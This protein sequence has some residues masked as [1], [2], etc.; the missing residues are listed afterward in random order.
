VHALRILA[1]VTHNP[2]SSPINAEVKDVVVRVAA[3]RG[4]DGA[5]PTNDEPLARLGFDSLLT[6]ELVARLEDHFDIEICDEFLVPSSFATVA[7]ICAIIDRL[8]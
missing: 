4:Y 7:S 1:T 5:S 2:S 6:I 8:R 3:T